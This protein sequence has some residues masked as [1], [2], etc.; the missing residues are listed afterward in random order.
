VSSLYR[1]Q[2]FSSWSVPCL[3][4]VPALFPHRRSGLSSCSRTTAMLLVCVL[5][6]LLPP[7]FSS[8]Q[9]SDLVV[10]VRLVASFVLLHSTA[11]VAH[12]FCV[13][14]RSRRGWALFVDR[15]DLHLGPRGVVSPDNFFYCRPV[16]FHVPCCRLFSLIQS[17]AAIVRPSIS[18]S[19]SSRAISVIF[20]GFS[21]AALDFSPP[22]ILPFRVSRSSVSVASSK[23]LSPVLRSR[24]ALRRRVL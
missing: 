18:R 17:G 13:L 1:R 4:C 24:I 23:I 16:S 5:F 20:P 2:K 9:A 19:F 22:R 12:L 6:D 21:L 10:F 14:P 7:V 3:I 8:V 11:G 15:M